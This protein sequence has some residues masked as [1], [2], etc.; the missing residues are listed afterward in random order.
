MT[1]CENC[2]KPILFIPYETYL[3]SEHYTVCKKCKN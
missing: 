2:G 1:K 3:Y